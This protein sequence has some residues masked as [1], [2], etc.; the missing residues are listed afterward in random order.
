[1]VEPRNALRFDRELRRIAGMDADYFTSFYRIFRDVF[2]QESRGSY[3]SRVSEYVARLF[4]VVGG[5][6]PI[7]TMTSVQDA[8]PAGGLNLLEVANLSHFPMR[9]GSHEWQQFWLP[10]VCSLIGDFARRTEQKLVD[11]LYAN[12]CPSGADWVNPPL[13][14][15]GD[16]RRPVHQ[17]GRDLDTGNEALTSSDFQEELTEIMTGQDW[18]DGWLFIL[19]NDVPTALLGRKLIHRRGATLHHSDTLIRKY[20]E[21]LQSRRQALLDGERI[22]RVRLLIPL[23]LREWFVS[24]PAAFSPYAEGA[25]A[26]LPSVGVLKEVWNEFCRDWIQTGSLRIFCATQPG[27]AYGVPEVWERLVRSGE[28]RVNTLPDVWIAVGAKVI[29]EILSLAHSALSES[30]ALNQE[31]ALLWWIASLDEGVFLERRWYESTAD[32][33]VMRLRSWTDGGGIR[34]IKISRSRFNPRFMGWKLC[35]LDGVRRALIHAAAAYVRSI[36]ARQ[37]EMDLLHGLDDACEATGRDRRR[38]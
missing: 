6:D 25:H 28:G 29:K 32:D 19:R 2:L 30:T 34:V 1:M 11:S 7:V 37:L 27:R 17:R 23:E 12:W 24:P 18:Q 33:E 22:H 15:P 14:T 21:G 35:D 31:S 13:E 4:F 10:K 5:N 3:S 36:D 38:G 9:K 26:Q 8:S 16:S 20:V